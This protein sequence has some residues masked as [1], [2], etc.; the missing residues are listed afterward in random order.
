MKPTILFV[1][2]IRP[3]PLYGGMY[4]QIYNVLESLCQYYNIIV[5]APPV[6]EE[7]PLYE[8]VLAWYPLPT[9]AT[10]FRNKVQNGVYILRPRP[11]WQVAIKE[12]LQR[13]QPDGV[14]FIYGHWGQYAPLIHQMGA[15]TVMMTHNVQ[16]SLTTQRATTMPLSP[17]YL[18]TQARAWAEAWHEHRL[19]AN[20]DRVIS[21]TDIDR[22]YHAQFVGDGRSILIPGFVPTDRYQNRSSVK[23]AEQLLILT[24]SFDSFQNI[25]GARWFIKEIWP[26]IRAAYP[27]VR[28]QLVGK[29]ST[30]LPAHI[31]ADPAVEAIGDVPDITPYLWR[32]TVAVVPI[33]H[34]SG[35]RFKILEALA[36]KLPVVSTTLGAQGIEVVNG[37]SIRLADQPRAFADAVIQL[38]ADR[39]QR[40][41]IAE[42]GFALLCQQYSATVN[43]IRIQQLV[44][45]LHSANESPR[46]T[47]ASVRK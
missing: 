45:C 7:C 43:T 2:E 20:F 35:I 30:Q 42:Q 6:G 38:L 34:G 32:A 13:H 10:G 40:K 8:Q 47:R 33:L 3:Y 24:G 12:I 9:Y 39:K 15:F 16:S 46:R 29:G 44:H 1:T 14:W 11:S 4:I 22:R 26:R 37:E 25:Q 31:L 19:F 18:L 23:R 41:Q 36:C 28:L 21:L 17:L 27:E 5:L